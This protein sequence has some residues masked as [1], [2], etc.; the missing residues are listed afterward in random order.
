MKKYGFAL[1][2]AVLVMITVLCMT[3]T[4]MG[5][6]QDKLGMS[7]EYYH[8]MEKEYVKQTRDRLNVLGYEN[9]GVSMT[10]ITNE[11]GSHEYTVSIHHAR[12]DAMDETRQ[13][14]LL[15]E[16]KKIP[17]AENNCD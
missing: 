1:F 7:D 8:D 3:G 2:T 16:L 10:M 6:N 15:A 9:A 11:D 5:Q 14:I 17:F 4:V 13:E 12:I